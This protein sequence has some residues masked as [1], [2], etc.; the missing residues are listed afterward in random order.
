VVCEVCSSMHLRDVDPLQA[1][2]PV[3]VI[4]S[5]KPACD[6][7]ECMQLISLACPWFLQDLKEDFS[8]DVNDNYKRMLGL[9]SEG[10]WPAVSVLGM[11]FDCFLDRPDDFAR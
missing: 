2:V 7:E 6:K 11:P 1:T 4:V 10:Q 5:V 9:E 3:I 8:M